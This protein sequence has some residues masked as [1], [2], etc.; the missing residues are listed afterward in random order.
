MDLRV[1]SNNLSMQLKT[2]LVENS[3]KD[4]PSSDPACSTQTKN[5]M[6]EIRSLLENSSA[7]VD[8]STNPEKKKLRLHHLHIRGVISSRVVQ[9]S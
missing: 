6:E 2:A 3:A 7:K 8:V 1:R 4:V 9:R 5:T